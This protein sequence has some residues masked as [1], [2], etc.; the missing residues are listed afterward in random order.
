[1]Y[2]SSINRAFYRQILDA[3][4]AQGADQDEMHNAVF[5]FLVFPH[6][7]GQGFQR[8]RALGR[9]AAAAEIARKPCA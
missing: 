1:M 9:Q 8:E 6:C 7:P 3:D 4:V 5:G 2:F